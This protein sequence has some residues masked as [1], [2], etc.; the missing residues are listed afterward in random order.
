MFHILVRVLSNNQTG[1]P[2]YSLTSF[3]KDKFYKSHI[4]PFFY[5][6]INNKTKSRK[7]T[8]NIYLI[9]KFPIKKNA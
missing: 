7:S 3:T 2:M 5:F 8:V 6:G 4:C 1:N 9:P